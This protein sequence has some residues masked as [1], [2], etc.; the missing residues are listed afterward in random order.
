M[1]ELQ[2]GLEEVQGSPS[3]SGALRLIVRRPGVDEREIVEQGQLDLD[4]GLVGDSW[5]ERASSTTSDGSPNPNAQITVMNARVATLIAGPEERWALAGDQLFVDL[6][7][8]E[9]RLPAGTRL[10]IGRAVIEI[11]AEP[12]SGCAKFGARFGND[13]LRFVNT[14]VGRTLN[15]RGRNA[16]VVL[17]GIIERGDAVHLERTNA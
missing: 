9:A 6:D 7:L 12:H 14:G 13:A 10:A 2:A 1:S 17:P 3:G 8:S 15:F 11:T 4:V 16:R 5:G